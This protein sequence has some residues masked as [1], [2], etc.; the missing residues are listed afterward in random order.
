MTYAGFWIR[1]G[2]YFIDAIL[3]FIVFYLIQTIT[4]IDMGTNFSA[5]LND[6]AVAGGTQN[7]SPLGSLISIAIGVGYFAG[8]ESSNWQASVGK[9]MLGL[10]VIDINGN[11]ISFL[12][13]VGR[14]FAKI[15]SA[16][17]LLIGFIMVAF[18]DK[19]QGLHDLIVGTL[20]VKGKPGEHSN[21]GVF[22]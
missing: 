14:Y 6:A 13:A 16:L 1:V 19:K 5:T 15:L 18:T 4:G 10:V 3:L 12:K 21:A 7:A 2:A 9:K 17:I 22:E 20:V 8:L 11:R